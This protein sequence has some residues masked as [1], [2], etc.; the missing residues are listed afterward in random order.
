MHG[1]G[2]ALQTLLYF[3]CQNSFVPERGDEDDAGEDDDG[4][5]GGAVE[6]NA[7]QAALEGLPKT[8]R[9]RRQRHRKFAIR[10]R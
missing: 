9:R 10:V 8:R 5:D 6:E 4:D 7:V 2:A 3:G 1:T